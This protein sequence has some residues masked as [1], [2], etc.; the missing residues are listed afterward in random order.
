MVGFTPTMSRDVSIEDSS[1]RVLNQ[2]KLASKGR[3][4]SLQRVVAALV[5][6][7]CPETGHK[8]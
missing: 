8:G 6:A 4:N 5:A 7:I 1:A 3:E 2:C